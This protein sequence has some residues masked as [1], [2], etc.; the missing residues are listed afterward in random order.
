MLL[1]W[2]DRAAN[3]LQIEAFPDDQVLALRDLLAW[4]REGTLTDAERA[5]LDELLAL[6]RRGMVRK[7]QALKVAVDSGYTELTLERSTSSA[8]WSRER[9]GET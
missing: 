1:E 5:R 2:L 6:Y 8:G 7:S 4:Q 9:G 3:D